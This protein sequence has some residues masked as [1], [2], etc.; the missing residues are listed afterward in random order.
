MHEK[1]ISSPEPPDRVEM[2]LIPEDAIIAVETSL[3][4]GGPSLLEIKSEADLVRC[5]CVDLHLRVSVV[6]NTHT[7]TIHRERARRRRP[8]AAPVRWPRGPTSSEGALDGVPHP[9]P[10][11]SDSHGRWFLIW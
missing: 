10:D 3:A 6:R 7:Q 4:H 8:Q 9:L 2:C 1:E 5:L 11:R